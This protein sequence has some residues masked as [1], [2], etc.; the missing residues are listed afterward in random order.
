MQRSWKWT[1]H[2]ID[3]LNKVQEVLSEFDK[4]KP[5][6]LRQVYYQLVGKGYIQNKVSEYNML[7]N[8]LKWGRLD[9]YISWNDIEDRVR[10]YYSLMGWEDKDHFINDSLEQFLTSYRRDLMQGQKAYIELWIE[11]D[12][13]SSIFIRLALRYTIPVVVCRGFSSISFLNNFRERLAYHTDKIPLMLYFG[14]FDPSGMEILAAIQKTLNNEM[15]L[16]TI[17]FKRIALLRDDIFTYNLPHNP[18]ALKKTDT[19]AKKHVERYG[20]LAVELDALRPDVLEGKI[21]NA[22]ESELDMDIFNAQVRKK[23]VEIDML[24]RLKK[25]IETLVSDV[26]K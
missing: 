17:E 7:S 9:G 22:I 2:Q 6:T 15:D 24:N 18:G 8:L 16:D 5:L 11:K 25:Q 13:L 1:K 20:E 4:Y 21:R 3:K 26:R 14:D 19:R 23:E 10:A 12:A